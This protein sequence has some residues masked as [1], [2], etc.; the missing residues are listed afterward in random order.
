MFRWLPD[1]YRMDIWFGR[2]K[3]LFSSVLKVKENLETQERTPR[4]KLSFEEDWYAVLHL[5]DNYGIP[6]LRL[7]HYWSQ[8][9]W[10]WRP[11]G[12]REGQKSIPRLGRRSWLL[13]GSYTGKTAPQER[14]SPRL[15]VSHSCRRE[16][17]YHQHDDSQSE[18]FCPWRRRHSADS[19]SNIAAWDSRRICL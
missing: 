6:D 7:G 8:V 17:R 2:S 15:L 4:W 3:K 5:V 18:G 11:K 16:S 14:G 9:Q 1:Q 13:L 12:P 19:A 10:S